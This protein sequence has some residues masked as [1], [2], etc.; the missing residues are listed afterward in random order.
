M[1]ISKINMI[2]DHMLSYTGWWMSKFY[3]FST[4]LHTNIL[5]SHMHYKIPPSYRSY[6]ISSQGLKCLF[7]FSIV[8]AFSPHIASMVSYFIFYTLGSCI[9][10]LTN[11]SMFWLNADK[12]IETFYDCIK[13]VL[14][15]EIKWFMLRVWE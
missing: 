12:D 3:V 7:Y 11:W 1:K 4:F 2:Y 8:F 13:K 10:A 6:L 14:I 5:D 9:N 15:F